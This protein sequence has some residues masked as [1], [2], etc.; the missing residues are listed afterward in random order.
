MSAEWKDL[1]AHV[2]FIDPLPGQRSKI[3]EPQFFTRFRDVRECR[4]LVEKWAA[5][6][7]RSV[8]GLSV[9]VRKPSPPQ[10]PEWTAE[11]LRGHSVLA[12]IALTPR[13]QASPLGQESL[14]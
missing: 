1:E 10:S 4:L 14:L 12:K 8:K 5:G 13:R 9:E 2:V 11:V 6:Q 7:W 3:V